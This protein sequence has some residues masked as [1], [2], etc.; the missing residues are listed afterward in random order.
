MA[1]WKKILVDGEALTS[2]TAG[3][4]LNGGTITSS[5]TI[6]LANTAVTAG[7]YTSANITVDAQGRLTS[8]ASG[9]S[10]TV[11][12]VTGVTSAGDYGTGADITFLGAT[13]TTCYSRK[14]LLLERDHM[15]RLHF[16][17]RSSS[18]GSCWGFNWDHYG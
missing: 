5:G 10:G 6:D 14:A 16:C 18:D 13:G 12:A 17:N 15:D 4:G 9:T 8:A 1:T 3:T 7:S 2:I 11:T